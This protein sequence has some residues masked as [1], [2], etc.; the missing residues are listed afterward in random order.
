MKKEV[1]LDEIFR[2][3]EKYYYNWNDW[4]WGKSLKNYEFGHEDNSKQLENGEFSASVDDSDVPVLTFRS[5]SVDHE[6]EDE[7]K[8]LRRDSLNTIREENKM[9]EFSFKNPECHFIPPP[10]VQ[11]R[12]YQ[13][14]PYMDFL[15]RV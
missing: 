6:S 10:Y 7:T 14:V 9:P 4:D 15:R 11:R 2:R 3:T 8:T 12:E 1:F 13:V 5:S